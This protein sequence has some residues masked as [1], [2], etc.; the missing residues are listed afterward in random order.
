MYR[1]LKYSVSNGGVVR[2]RWHQD[3]LTVFAIGVLIGVALAITVHHASDMSTYQTS[4]WQYFAPSSGGGTGLKR[5]ISYLDG[6]NYNFRFEKWLYTVFGGVSVNQDPDAYRYTEG[7][8][9]LPHR[10]TYSN[11]SGFIVTSQAHFLYGHVP[12]ICVV[13]N[14]ESSK[15]VA[16]VVNTWGKHC[17]QVRFYFTS[18]QG[19]NKKVV[20][21]ETM[22]E[23]NSQLY[24]K[25]RVTEVPLAQSEFGLICRAFRQ[26]YKHHRK[27]VKAGLEKSPWVM[28]SP[29]NSFVLTENLR[30][31]VAPMNSSAPHYIG[32]AM[33]FWGA[34]YNW[35]QAGYAI[36][37]AALEAFSRKFPTDTQCDA[38]GKF[39]KNGDWYLGKHL[40]TLGIKPID[41]RDHIGRGRFNGYSMRKLL[42]PGGVSSFERYWRDSFFGTSPDGPR[43]CSN[44][45]VTFAGVLSSSKMY[46][47]DYLHHRLRPFFK[48]G[49]LGNQPPKSNMVD[50]HPSLTLNEA[51]KEQRLAQLFDP[52]LTTPKNWNAQDHP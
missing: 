43:C 11:T 17:N 50:K 16:A 9:T 20:F 31:Y 27:R 45:A 24:D 39:W 14:P 8:R 22:V 34:V 7:D 2:K 49:N 36:S 21:N 44:F 18:R 51:L 47:Q 52:T 29:D 33:K 48:G 19:A 3:P 42:V 12:V 1:K 41:T 13:F 38:G 30:F 35:A 37:W 4:L 23:N 15:N 46:Q 32:H 40:A 10:P 25:V 28:V 26:I 6:S 5:F